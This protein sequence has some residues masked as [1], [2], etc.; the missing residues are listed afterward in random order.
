MQKTTIILALAA[1]ALSSAANAQTS[2]VS[3]G[4]TATTASTSAG[5]AVVFAP[6][7]GDSN[8][9]YAA[10]SAIAP[11]L[12][13]GMTTCMG[14]A[15]VGFQVREFGFSSGKTYK[16]EDCQAGNFAQTLWNQGYRAQ[17]IGVLCSRPLIRYAVATQGGI[18]Y[19]RDDGVIVHRA[20]PMT[21]E[22]WHSAGEPLLDPIT[23]RPMTEGEMNPPIKVSVA[24]LTPEQKKQQENVALIEQRAVDIARRQDAVVA[25]K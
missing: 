3:S 11:G 17:A 22:E 19:R 8:V 24:P 16:D 7:S 2:G 20:C 25:A 4:A 23:G 18:P 6:T 14:S 5:G 12:V 10:N 21:P 13:A 15:S 1:V 9:N